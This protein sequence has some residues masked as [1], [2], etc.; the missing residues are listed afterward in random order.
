MAHYAEIKDGIVERVIV[1][2]SKEWCQTNLGGEWVQTSYNTQGG[3]HTLGGTPLHKNYAGIGYT[4]DGIGFASPQP[5]PSWTLDTD[6]YL[7]TSPIPAPTDGMYSWNEETQSW[8]LI[9]IE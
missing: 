2:D 3:E 5:Y 1:A 8:D 6:T 4:W 7:W 9:T